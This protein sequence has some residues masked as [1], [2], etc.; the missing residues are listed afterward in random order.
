VPKTVRNV[1][2]YAHIRDQKQG[3]LTPQHYKTLTTDFDSPLQNSK[4]LEVVRKVFKNE[5]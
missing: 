5:S 1:M 4:H 3:N 2:L